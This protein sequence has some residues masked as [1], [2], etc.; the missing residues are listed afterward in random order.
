MPAHNNCVNKR[1]FATENVSNFCDCEEDNSGTPEL[2][3][4]NDSGQNYR[5]SLSLSSTSNEDEKI[6]IQTYPNLSQDP[7]FFFY[8][9]FSNDTHNLACSSKITW[10]VQ[11]ICFEITWHE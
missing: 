4:D 2:H 3:M 6:K 9:F 10:I 8:N 7:L 11:L 1:N 5:P